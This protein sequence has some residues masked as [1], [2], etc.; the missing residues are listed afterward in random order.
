[1]THNPNSAIQQLD[2]IEATAYRDMFAAAP[3]KLVQSL[4][5]QCDE[6]CGATA[7]IIKGLPTPVFN[8]V[9][10]LGSYHPVS[11]DDINTITQHYINAGI[12]DWW[13]H[14]SPTSFNSQ[15]NN[16]LL[17]RGFVLAQRRAWVKFLRNDT[18]YPPV[19]TQA[20]IKLITADEAVTLAET[21]CI[22][23]EMPMNLVPWFS[24]LATRPHWQAVGAYLGDQLVGGGCLFINR[25][26]AW[27]GAG[28]VRPE[29]RGQ[30]VH[31]ALLFRRI[32]RAIAAVCTQLV[33]ETGEPIGNEANPSYRNIEACG[34]R[35]I[36][37]RMNYAP[38]N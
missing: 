37:S 7:L 2:D 30:H 6:I 35:N 17:K 11:E 12:K 21:I 20:Q 36:F 3:A 28:G 1:M 5:L 34:F 14:V 24:A 18:Q 19:K 26:N 8:R 15:L 31:R 9:I 25:N 27:L 16:I 32:E 10:G 22:A 4:G 23:F 33:T 29:A 13:L 38:P